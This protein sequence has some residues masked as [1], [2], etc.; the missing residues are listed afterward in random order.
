MSH[1]KIGHYFSAQSTVHCIDTKRNLL[2]LSGLAV[3]AAAQIGCAILC[4][5]CSLKSPSKGGGSASLLTGA[6]H[7]LVLHCRPFRIDMC[8]GKNDLVVS[9]NSQQL[10]KIEHMS[11]R[12]S[13]ETHR[14]CCV[15]AGVSVDAR[16]RTHAHTVCSTRRIWRRR[17]ANHTTWTRCRQ[18]QYLPARRRIS[19]MHIHDVQV[20]H[21]H[22]DVGDQMIDD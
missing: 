6:D 2:E 3:R 1:E 16:A 19:L 4:M 22:S 5:F 17:A 13:I 12:R 7:K 14:R 11:V 18:S 15:S 8:A 9:L 21:I 10:I 20:V